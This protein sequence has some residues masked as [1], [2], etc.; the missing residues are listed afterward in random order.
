MHED[1]NICLVQ[2]DRYMTTALCCRSLKQHLQNIE[3][4]STSAVAITHHFLTQL[5]LPVVAML[6]SLL[7]LACPKLRHT[8]YRMSADHYKAGQHTY[9]WHAD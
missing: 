9:V 5:V 3:C 8:R 2:A 4:N 6:T 7:C 1:H